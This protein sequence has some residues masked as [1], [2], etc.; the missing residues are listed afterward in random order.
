[1]AAAR[2]SEDS[3]PIAEIV[4]AAARGAAEGSHI[5]ERVAT[6]ERDVANHITG[7]KEALNRMA[8]DVEKLTAAISKLSETVT[9]SAAGNAVRFAVGSKAG[10]WVMGIAGAV[11]G[12]VLTAAVV[13]AI[14][15]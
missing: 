12:S 1:M 14:M 5:R 9:A 10:G 7:T 11:L 15:R 2:S 3:A 4:H 8:G 6:L 13:A